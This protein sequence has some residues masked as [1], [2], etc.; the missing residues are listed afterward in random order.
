ENGAV[1]Q[2]FYYEPFGGRRDVDGSPSNVAPKDVPLGFTGQRHDDE[3]GLI[4]FQ[5]RVY[6]PEIRRFLT[7]DPHVTDPLG[8]QSYNRY[9]YV[10]NNPI[11]LVDPT[12]FDWW[13]TG[14]GGGCIGLECAGNPGG[15]SG[16]IGTDEEFAAGPAGIKWI[17]PGGG[18][19]TPRFPSGGPISSVLNQRPI[20]LPA[21]PTAPASPLAG[22]STPAWVTSVTGGDP[23]WDEQIKGGIVGGLMLGY[24]P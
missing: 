22:P 23:L 16:H 13:D 3:L 8:G 1:V 21:G 12:G 19:P 24:V 11:N 6:D 14:D 4:D 7:P 20:S 10:V 17:A 5:G 15:W 18:P 9:S 2:T